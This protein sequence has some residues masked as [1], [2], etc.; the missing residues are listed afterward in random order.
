MGVMD[1][2]KFSCQQA[3]ALM[4]LRDLRPL[5]ARER[6]GLWMHRRICDGCRAYERHSR[7]ID[8]LLERRAGTTRIDTSELET[9][10]LSR[11]G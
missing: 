11:I 10:I 1:T 6:L 9:R 8:N 2:L 3:T 7:V 5:G 4:E